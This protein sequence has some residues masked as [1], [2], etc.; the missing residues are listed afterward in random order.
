MASP[1]GI[2]KIINKTFSTRF[3]L[4]RLSHHAFFGRL[5]DFLLFKDD[6]I[7]YLP[8]DKTIPI[9]RSLGAKSDTVLPSQILDKII[10]SANH[11]W[12]MNFCICRESSHCQDFPTDLGCLF[13][14]EAVLDINPRFGRLVDAQEASQ[15]ARMCR[16][17]GLVH[18]VGRNKLDSVWLNARPEGK[19]F[20]VCNCCPCCCF[21]RLL[22][23]LTPDIGDKLSRM[24]GISLWVTQECIGC[25]TCTQ[26]VCFVDAIHL[27]G[28]KAHIGGSCR[29]CGRCVDVCPNQA[30]E[31]VI[32]DKNFDSLTLKRLSN[33][34]DLS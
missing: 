28:E 23:E 17:E 26:D 9:D 10:D 8:R 16:E 31:L 15:H 13:M 11:H 5:I 29:G 1:Y 18:L 30:I 2:K 22:P 21:W 6:D 33:A 3:M 20:T 24:P 4:S 27:E 32:S 7:M 19:L 34:V 12:I 25:G 14:G